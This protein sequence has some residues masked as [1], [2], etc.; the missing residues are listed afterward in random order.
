M[1]SLVEGSTGTPARRLLLL[2]GGLAGAPPW[3]RARISATWERGSSLRFTGGS[4]TGSGV[5]LCFIGSSFTVSA[6]VRW[7]EA[8]L[9][10]IFCSISD[11]DG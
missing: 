11:R 5:T 2:L 6:A 3:K 10:L 8:D 1:G 9:D 7:R 4:I